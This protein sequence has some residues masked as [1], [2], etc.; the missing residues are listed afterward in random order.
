MAVVQVV[1]SGTTKDPYLSVYLR[2]LWLLPASYDIDL[3]VEHIQ[4]NKNVTADLLSRLY[5][6]KATNVQLLSYLQSNFT[7][8]KVSIEDLKV[9]FNI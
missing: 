7:W 8:D 1:A 2:N 6:N 3:V 4:G 9:D 5:S